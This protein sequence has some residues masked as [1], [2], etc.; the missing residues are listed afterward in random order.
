METESNVECASA[1]AK[2][3][4]VRGKAPRD[5][6]AVKDLGPKPLQLSALLSLLMVGKNNGFA[7]NCNPIFVSLHYR[8]IIT[9]F[10]SSQA[11]TP[12]HLAEPPKKPFLASH[13]H[14]DRRYFLKVFFASHLVHLVSRYDTE[15]P[16]VCQVSNFKKELSRVLKNAA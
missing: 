1:R 8:S 13:G 5:R 6:Y 7:F 16:L 9:R 2:S 10:R 12:L 15:K 3:D 4:G 14:F 11:H